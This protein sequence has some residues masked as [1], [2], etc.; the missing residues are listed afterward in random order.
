MRVRA[1]LLSPLLPLVSR[2]PPLPRGTARS[3]E[4][5]EPPEPL[6]PAARGLAWPSLLALVEAHPANSERRD[7]AV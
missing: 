7:G 4:P 2:P 6:E 3:P 1:P 5:P